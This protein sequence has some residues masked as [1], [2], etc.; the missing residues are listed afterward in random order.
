VVWLR[1]LARAPIQTGIGKTA[2]WDIQEWDASDGLRGH[3]DSGR[4]GSCPS[5]EGS[6]G[7]HVRVGDLGGD[8]GVTQGWSTLLPT[9]PRLTCGRVDEQAVEAH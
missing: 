9:P 7:L 3:Q 6:P 5:D 8:D 1:T 4:V 2:K